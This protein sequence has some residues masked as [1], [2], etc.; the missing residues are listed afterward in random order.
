MKF[1]II[2]NGFD[3]AH[4]LNTRFTDFEKFANSTNPHNYT[5]LY[6]FGYD[7]NDLWGDFENTIA[8]LDMEMFMA[9][10]GSIYNKKDV[11]E[12]E[13]NDT[14]LV[15]DIDFDHLLIDYNECKDDI[16]KWL[17]SMDM[18][19]KKFELDETDFYLTFN[20]TL[21]LE[22]LYGIPEPNVLHIHGDLNSDLVI[23]YDNYDL[24]EAIANASPFPDK[25]FPYELD[26]YCIMTDYF[27]K[28][29]K[30]TKELLT[31]NLDFLSKSK[32]A[33]EIIIYSLSFSKCDEIYLDSIF[34]SLRNEIII[35]I[36]YFSD[37]DYERVNK[38]I[39]K[40]EN[41]FKLIK[42]REEKGIVKL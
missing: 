7:T 21:L 28:F 34:K 2:G 5:C 13:I 15:E 20:Y 14:I 33:D 25:Q 6:D 30:N 9:Y 29:H 1:Y 10:A 39:R 17:I 36:Y 37:E 27:K 3:I 24:D 31:K 4:G 42:I 16:R 38:F 41:N 40:Y 23:G 12:E 11:P 8:K 22:K 32:Y 26:G 35:K 19:S 18:P